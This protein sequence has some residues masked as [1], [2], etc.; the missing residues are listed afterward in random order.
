MFLKIY[1][2][3]SCPFCVSAKELAKKLK[4]S[5]Y[6][7]DFEYIDY[8]AL[9]LSVPQLSEIAGREVKT[10]PVILLNGVYIGGFTDLKAKFAL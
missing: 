2:R 4:D 8:Q 5:S 3:D 7:E 9:G 10:V 6:V 1:G